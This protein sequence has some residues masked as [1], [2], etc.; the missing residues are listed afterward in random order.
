ML[1][2][3]KHLKTILEHKY[4][5]WYF[6]RKLGIGW[7]T[8]WHDMSK[9]NPVEFRE[10]VKYYTGTRSPIDVC[11]EINGYSEAWLHHKG[12]NKHHYEYWQDNFDRGG[13]SIRMPDKYLKEMLC[14]YLAAGRTYNGKGFNF[15]ME[16]V[17]WRGKKA[18]PLAMHPHTMT[19]IDE[20]MEYINRAYNHRKISA[21][22]KKEWEALRREVD[23]LLKVYA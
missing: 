3:L 10:S 23:R 21:I 8:F 22:T 12:R 19:V 20:C 16:Y 18:K 13:E 4:W 2:S 6:G 9:F 14:D 15:H 11:K 17:W 1:K 5:V 7:Q